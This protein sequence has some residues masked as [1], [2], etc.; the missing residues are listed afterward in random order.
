MEPGE[1]VRTR[2]KY[3]H[4]MHTANLER[5][6]HVLTKQSPLQLYKPLH[7]LGPPSSSA[8][9]SAMSPNHSPLLIQSRHPSSQSHTITILLS[10]PMSTK[11]PHHHILS[12]IIMSFSSLGHPLHV[13]G[14]YSHRRRCVTICCTPRWY[15]LCR[16]QVHK[17]DYP[18]TEPGRACRLYT[19]TREYQGY[20]PFPSTTRL[21][22]GLARLSLPT[23][24]TP[25]PANPG[26]PQQ[27]TSQQTFQRLAG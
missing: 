11:L 6:S 8:Q 3:A 2:T 26:Q 21:T 1:P 27:P 7:T 5:P 20:H 12:P 25:M 13:H 22:L 4:N 10:S 14:H 16:C 9:T 18:T 24:C 17:F 15:P 19:I 23:I